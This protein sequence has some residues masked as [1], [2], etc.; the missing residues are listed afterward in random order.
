MK[1]FTYD[2][3]AQERIAVHAVVVGYDSVIMH[4]CAAIETEITELAVQQKIGW[5]AKERRIMVDRSLIDVYIR[6]S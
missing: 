2:S 4:A 1:S 5:S 6:T 3:G